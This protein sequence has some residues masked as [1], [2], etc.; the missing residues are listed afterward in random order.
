MRAIPMPAKLHQAGALFRIK[1]PALGALEE[2]F[3]FSGSNE[4]HVPRILR[5]SHC[6]HS[7]LDGYFH[8]P[9]W[10]GRAVRRFNK[11]GV[12]K[13][14]VRWAGHEHLSFN[15]VELSTMA[16][17]LQNLAAFHKRTQEFACTIMVNGDFL[18]PRSILPFWQVC[19]PLMPP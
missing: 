19:H 4:N 1:F 6:D 2:R 12:G 18:F 9:A 13:L 10:R 5:I 15:A 14:E 8:A 3:P 11:I 17:F 16:G 7:I